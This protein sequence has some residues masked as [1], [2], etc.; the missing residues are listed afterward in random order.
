MKV[1]VSFVAGL[2]LS[3]PAPALSAQAA[4]PFVGTWKLNLEKSQ[5]PGPPPARAYIVTYEQN[6]DGS[7]LGVVYELDDERG[8]T[9]V[10]RITYRY[11]GREYRDEDVRNGVPARNTLA[12]SQIDARTVEVTHKLNEGKL[13]F[14]EMRR[15]AEDGR[16][17]TFVLTARDQQGRTV[18]VVQ[19][20]DRQ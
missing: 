10:A 1:L 17:M 14:K 6:A 18:S 3:V 9:A 16:T 7:F 11:D 12:F 13:V 5:F 20:F 19:V 15:V 4:D 8:R 2:I